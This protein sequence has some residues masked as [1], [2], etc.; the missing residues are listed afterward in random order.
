M[1]IGTE[2]TFFVKRYIDGR[3]ISNILFRF[4]SLLLSHCEGGQ[5]LQQVAP[6]ACGVSILG[7]SKSGDGPGQP[8]L[9]GAALSR[10]I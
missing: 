1:L 2:L 3:P 6:R 9:V 4:R 7:D 5:A 8:A 10:G